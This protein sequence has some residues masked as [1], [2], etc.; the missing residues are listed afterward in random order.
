MVA[1][2]LVN[3]WGEVVPQWEYRRMTVVRRPLK[4]LTAML[5]A[6]GHE[7]WEMV[8]HKILSSDTELFYFKRPKL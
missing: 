4:E 1:T 8:S 3:T 7:G 2:K 5:D 6:A